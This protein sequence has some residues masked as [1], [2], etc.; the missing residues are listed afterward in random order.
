MNLKRLR[1]LV[2][3]IVRLRPRPKIKDAYLREADNSWIIVQ[4]VKEKMFQLICQ[5]SHH[6]FS[7]A[8]DNIND[9]RSPNFLI[10]RGQVTLKEGG[11]VE[12]EPSGRGL[13]DQDSMDQLV[14]DITRLKGNSVYE[15][16]KPYTGKEVTLR[17]PDKGD[18]NSY[19]D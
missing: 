15:A 18:W 17:F 19:E 13:S 7:I 5:S 9:F 11:Q 12:F 3:T 14:D 8:A 2:G 16:L 6:E 1:E 10:L 4:E